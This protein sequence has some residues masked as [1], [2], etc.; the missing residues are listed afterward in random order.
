MRI[1]WVKPGKL[2]PLD[3]GG[4]LRTYNILKQLSAKYEV[5]YVSY[6]SGPKDN[7]YDDEIGLHIP[8][9]IPFN[10]GVRKSDG[11]RSY[12]SY[13]AK[14]PVPTPYSVIKFYSPA[15]QKLLAE[16]FRSNSFDIAVS[17]F[18]ASTPNFPSDLTI[19]TLLFQHNVETVLWKRRAEYATAWLTRAVAGIESAK[20]NFYETK[21][22]RRF[23]HV[24]AVSE[25]DRRALIAM[26]PSLQVSV[27]PTGVDLSTYQYDP[28]LRPKFPLVVFSGSMDWEPNI[29]GVEHFCRD[30]WPHVLNVFPKARFRI[31][32]R[33]PASRI[34]ALSSSSVEVTGTVASITEHLRE[35]AVLVVPLRMG[36]GTRIKIYEGMAM[37]KATVSTNVGAEGLNVRHGHDILL[38]DEPETFAAEIIRLL[39]DENLRRRYE[40]AAAATACQYDWS[41]VGDSFAAILKETLQAS[42]AFARQSVDTFES[43]PYT[44]N[45]GA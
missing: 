12:F 36:S 1:L 21:Q 20:I 39:S 11:W 27:V 31:V 5:T 18:L 19:P 24:A 23:H 34:R 40:S 14:L 45:G 10:T 25:Q 29:D 35:A 15:V 32:G 17:D 42:T 13:L 8:G 6:Y 4:K 44:G 3:T 28:N 30:I 26:S 33:N 43:I 37:G 22:L 41:V 2:L 38:A 9:A 16:M 7:Q